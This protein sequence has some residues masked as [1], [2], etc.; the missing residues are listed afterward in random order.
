MKYVILLGDG[1]ADHPLEELAG[2]TPLE[3]A[4]TPNMDRVA[5]M[6]FSGLFNPI[7]DGLPPGSD[8]G[9]LSVFGYDPRA[10]FSGRAA[11][12]AA[13]QGIVLEDDEVAFRCNLVC[14]EEG[15]MK[16]FTSGHISTEEARLLI[17][18]LN[19]ALGARFP[20]VLHPG[21][22]YRHTGIIKGT[23]DSS[24]QDLIDTYCEPPHNIT[25]QS[26]AEY[27]PK[28]PAAALLIELIHASQDALKGHKINLQRI[29]EG[30]FPAVSLWPWGQGKA[31]TLEPFSDRFGITGAVISAVDLVKG[32]GVCAGLEVLYVPGATGWIDTNYKGKVSAAQ[33]A[34]ERHSFVYLHLEAPDEAAHQGNIDLKIKAIELF[35]ANIV[36]PFI[37]YLGSHPETRLLVAP[38]HFTLIST[39][40]HATGYV[41]FAICGCGVASDGITTY[42][43]KSATMSTIKIKNG[44]E[45]TFHFLNDTTLG[46]SSFPYTV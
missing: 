29:R 45:L 32:I 8:V 20:I 46:P 31:L 23:A 37:D 35:D 17:T 44:H 41:P 10:C 28:G 38:D 43:E 14:L 6:G 11:I 39:K 5:E 26:F 22:S 30:K 12:E 42:N 7:P 4:H 27:L 13:S 15:R 24:V 1:M 36:G 34:L 33:E 16:D 3:V 18:D 40:T 2:H 25:G 21:V 19:A 9:N